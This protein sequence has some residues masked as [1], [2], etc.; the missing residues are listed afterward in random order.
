METWPESTSI[1]SYLRSVF[2]YRLPQV[3][4]Y[5]EVRFAAVPV[6]PTDQINGVVV[7][8]RRQL[9]RYKG[10]LSQ[11]F[12]DTDGN[13]RGVYFNPSVYL[14]G[15]T[16]HFDDEPEHNLVLIGR[17]KDITTSV[18]S[19]TKRVD[20]YHLEFTASGKKVLLFKVTDSEG[21]RWW[22][23][24]FARRATNTVVP[25]T[26]NAG[27]ETHSTSPVSLEIPR[28]IVRPDDSFD[29]IVG[30]N[31]PTIRLE[32][33]D[34][35]FVAGLWTVSRHGVRTRILYDLDDDYA[36]AGLQV[37]YPGE[38]PTQRKWCV[39]WSLRWHSNSIG[40]GDMQCRNNRIEEFSSP[41]TPE[42]LIWNEMRSQNNDLGNEEENEPSS[43]EEEYD[44]EEDGAS[45]H[46]GAPGGLVN[47]GN[48]C[49]INAALQLARAVMAH[50]GVEMGGGAEFFRNPTLTTLTKLVEDI[51]RSN[52]DFACQTMGDTNLVL[53]HLFETIP[54][55]AR[56]VRFEEAHRNSDTGFDSK[57]TRT[58]LTLPLD[59][60]IN[61]PLSLDSLVK[62]SIGRDETTTPIRVKYYT[63]APKVLAIQL[64][65]WKK[66]PV[67]GSWQ[68]N[69]RRVKLNPTLTF[70]LQRDGPDGAVTEIPYI[71]IGIAYYHK[72]RLHYTADVKQ[73]DGTWS[74]Y[75][76]AT[77]TRISGPK[78]SN[79]TAYMCV[80]A[81][82]D[83]D[84]GDESTKA[85][86]ESTKEG[87]EVDLNHSG[88]TTTLVLTTLTVTDILK[89]RAILDEHS[90]AF[91]SFQFDSYTNK[92]IVTTE[93][94][95]PQY[96]SAG[97]T[98]DDLHCKER[99][100]PAP[101][102]SLIVKTPCDRHDGR[103][104]AGSD[105][106]KYKVFVKGFR[107]FADYCRQVSTSMLLQ[108]KH[109]VLM[110]FLAARLATARAKSNLPRLTL[111]NHNKDVPI[112]HFKFVAEEDAT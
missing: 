34:A 14:L 52:P 6:Y 41:P 53:L 100:L 71:L 54:S 104:Y 110:K 38:H 86:D 106:G 73:L 58:I 76:D 45:K 72:A 22:I 24:M 93:K 28:V 2:S 70:P 40:A 112:L 89:I 99:A 19:G 91:A 84:S 35:S 46:V 62:D 66:T 63:S 61:S 68:F 13:T 37:L 85:G 88:D 30:G 74:N 10:E 31:R 7:A 95:E 12:S 96:T 103:P 107:N 44:D 108:A 47:L 109:P 15:R 49:Y 81:R 9:L 4:R 42:W 77:V 20:V 60:P 57:E 51:Q 48:T 56:Q 97:T 92:Y 98:W 94:D 78:A 33:C 39:L 1:E 11:L 67:S 64:L 25:G 26:T 16:R 36:L 111:T 90:H 83:D 27:K 65:R 80:Y 3:T 18:Q 8:L 5:Y 105:P 75:D 43:D 23:P 32:G 82:A 87:P 102:G 69:A 101:V 50:G 79:K 21:S 29:S 55:L 59:G 17:A